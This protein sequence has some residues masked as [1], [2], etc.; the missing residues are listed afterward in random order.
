MFPPG[1]YG[2]RRDRRRRPWLV[3]IL[4]VVIVAVLVAVAVKLYVA[5]GQTDFNPTVLRYSDIKQS[6]ITVRFQ[7]DKP[8]G[9]AAVCTVQ[10]YATD[11]TIVGSADVP[12]PAGRSV[13]VDYTLAT[14]GLAR[15]ADVTTC[16]A[17]G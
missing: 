4:A 8:G 11:G 2:H 6:S 9:A 17:A 10:A 15:A 1:R 14:T 3:R 7:V 16:H 12:V 5:Y 13:T